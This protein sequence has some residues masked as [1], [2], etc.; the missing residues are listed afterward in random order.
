MKQEH[1]KI[2]FRF[3]SDIFDE[4]MVETMWAFVIDKEKGLYK[5]DNI[6]FYAPLISSDDLIYAEYDDS[7]QML[8]YRETREYSGN[9]VIQ[10]VIM[11]D[12]NEVN[13]IR[14][15]FLDKGCQ[16]EKVN[17]KYFSME[18]P[19]DL[20]YEPIKTELDKLENDEI[21]G[22]AEPCLSEKHRNDLI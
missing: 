17:E 15:K 21:I 19:F 10:I 18:I 22:Y 4:E 13:K 3:H 5:L 7:E 6:P 1:E 20:D 11:G 12:T 8:T 9:S 16:S 2:L 14:D